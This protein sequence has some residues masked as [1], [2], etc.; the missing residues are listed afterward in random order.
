MGER[1]DHVHPKPKR[2]DVQE[3]PQG[4]EAEE[5][6]VGANDSWGSHTLRTGGE[7][8]W[9]SY[10]DLLGRGLHALLAAISSVAIAIRS[11]EV[12]VLRFVIQGDRLSLVGWPE[13]LTVEERQEVAA[14]IGDEFLKFGLVVNMDEI[15]DRCL[16]EHLSKK[17]R[18]GGE[19]GSWG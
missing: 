5:A 13:E 8:E 10:S 12:T 15:A 1:S 14:H 4:A 9:S 17:P 7:T 11:M 16:K 19:E 2:C 6:R 3:L 18:D